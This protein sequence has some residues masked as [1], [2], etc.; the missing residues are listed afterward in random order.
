MHGVSLRLG[1]QDGWV[2]G[3]RRWL[4]FGLA[5]CQGPVAM[6]VSLQLSRLLR[7]ISLLDGGG[8]GHEWGWK[9]RV[10]RH[11]TKN[12][13]H[14]TLDG[15]RALKRWAKKRTQ[16]MRPRKKGQSQRLGAV[17]FWSRQI[18]DIGEWSEETGTVKSAEQ[19][20][21][22]KEGVINDCKF[23]RGEGGWALK[24]HFWLFN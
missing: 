23:S 11:S 3:G 15:M 21:L 18:G 17:M 2:G 20:E 12:G 9:R 1:T 13:P 7:V 14:L 5:E 19:R 6:W 8:V 16:L 24:S 22:Q 10:K 4:S